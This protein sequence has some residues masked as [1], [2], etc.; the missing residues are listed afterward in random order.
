MRIRIDFDGAST[1]AVRELA[2]AL[3]NVGL[4]KSLAVGCDG[5]EKWSGTTPSLAPWQ[6]ASVVARIVK[7]DG[8]PIADTLDA[9]RAGRVTA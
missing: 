8:A 2:A 9:L 5:P 1:D 3:A 4:R 6:F 7:D